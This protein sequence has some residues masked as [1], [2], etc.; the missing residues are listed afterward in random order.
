MT[1]PN[2]DDV[3]EMLAGPEPDWESEPEAPPDAEQADK[4]LVRLR[5]VQRERERD[6]AAAETRISQI[7]NWQAEREG[8][9]GAREEW[10][11]QTLEHYHQ[12]VLRMDPNAKTIH[13]PSGDLP[14]RMGQAQWTIDD[15]EVLWWL[16]PDAAWEQ[17]DAA[18]DAYMRA[19]LGALAESSASGPVPPDELV[20]LVRIPVPDSLALDRNAFKAW[21]TRRDE[22]DRP[23]AWGVSPSGEPIPGVEVEKPE[24]NFQPP[25]LRLGDEVERFDETEGVA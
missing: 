1:I 8:T 5:M 21:A 17:I 12:A 16:V 4:M 25:K 18:R 19:V 2:F 23:K 9:Y 13:L 10:L 6:R 15:A 22:K 3:D 24:R 7:V 20:T 14:S 11:I